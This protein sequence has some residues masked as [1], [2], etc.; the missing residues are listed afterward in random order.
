M[1]IA[2]TAATATAIPE[3]ISTIK[4]ELEELKKR[5]NA[6]KKELEKL[7]EIPKYIDNA[8]KILTDYFGPDFFSDN[9]DS[10]EF[11]RHIRESLQKGLTSVPE[12]DTTVENA[13][14]D[15]YI[16]TDSITY[17]WKGKRITYE[18]VREDEYHNCEAQ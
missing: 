16:T 4:A 10:G 5:Q 15:I 11:E 1:A 7:V 9:G 6:L 13:K 2:A 3:R 18:V 17:T 8:V 14:R 12:E